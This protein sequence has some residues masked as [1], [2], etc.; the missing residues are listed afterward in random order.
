MVDV[1]DRVFLGWF[2]RCHKLAN[3]IEENRDLAVVPLDG[4]GKLAVG[5]ENLA[6]LDECADDRDVN[7]DRPFAPKDAG[8]HRDAMLREYPR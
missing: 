5:R 1:S 3:R 8:E 6:E 7:L 2:R 4:A